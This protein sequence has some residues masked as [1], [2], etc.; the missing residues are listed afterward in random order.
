[1]SGDGAFREKRRRP[2]TRRGAAPPL[3]RRRTDHAEDLVAWLL[4]SLGLLAVLGAVLVGQAA[5][6]AAL[7]RG[8]GASPVVA[9]V[10]GDDPG[11]HADQRIPAPRT[12]AMVGW[13]GVDGIEHVATASV[14]PS[15]PAGSAVTVWVDGAGRVVADPAERSAEA[16]A[17]GITAGLTV[18]ALSWALLTLLWSTVCRVTTACNAAGWSRE[19][20]RVEPQWRRSVR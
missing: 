15:L 5:H 12:H 10:L 6:Q 17:F 18:V 9:V 7:G 8:G 3:P 2:R 1:M 14:P 20:A 4:T 11:P 13:R 16:W 19:W